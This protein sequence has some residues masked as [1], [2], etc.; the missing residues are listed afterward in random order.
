MTQKCIMARKEAG[1]YKS[2]FEEFQKQMAN[3]EAVITDRVRKAIKEREQSFKTVLKEK[4]ATISKLVEHNKCFK[5]VIN[6]LEK[7]LTSTKED[8]VQSKFSQSLRNDTTK[9]NTGS[10]LQMGSVAQP[11]REEDLFDR[12]DL[13]DEIFEGNERFGA[14]VDDYKRVMNRGKKSKDNEMLS[15]TLNSRPSRKGTVAP[16]DDDTNMSL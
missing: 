1:Y 13:D 12:D 6:D 2:K 8:L 4:E 7:Q 3:L 5:E 15:L 14:I 11:H 10:K 16:F 9:V